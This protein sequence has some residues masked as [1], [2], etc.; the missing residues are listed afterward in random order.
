M[1]VP[2]PTPSRLSRWSNWIT[3]GLFVMALVPRMI[4]LHAF[5]VPDEF[6]WLGRSLDAMC[7]VQNGNLQAT[8]QSGHPGVT[9]LWGFGL[10]LLARFALLGDPSRI[11][12][13]AVA[14][15]YPEAPELLSTA[16]LFTVVV[17]SVGV[18]IG[19]RAL[20]HLVGEEVALLAA[21]LVA[22]DPFYLDQ[23][24]LVHV[25][26]LLAT[27]MSLSVLALLAHSFGSGGR[28]YLLASGILAGLAFLTKLPSLVLIPFA[29]LT[30]GFR[31]AFIARPRFDR[32]RIGEM[33]NQLGLWAIAA[34]VTFVA[35]WPMMW[36]HPIAMLAEILR[37]SGW[38]ASVP[39]HAS[40]FMGR[41]VS[42][43]GSLY[44][45]VV[46]PF[47]LTPLTM[48]AAP[49]SLFSA[50]ANVWAWRKGDEDARD[51][52]LAIA[53]AWAF[54]LAFLIPMSLSAKKGERY[55]LPIFPIVDF[56][57]AVG[58][59]GA[60]S[61]MIRR[62][63]DGL[64]PEILSFLRTGLPLAL[65]LLI[66]VQ[67][68]SL[69][70]HYAA[71]YNPILGG[72]QAA[73][74]M[75]VV[76]TGEGL[77][78]AARYLDQKE[79]AEH[80]IVASFYPESF[81]EYFRGS[82]ISLRYGPEDQ[83]W[84]LSDYVVFYVSQ[85]QRELPTSDMVSFFRNQ[86][87]EHV[88]TINGLEYAWVYP[89]PVLKSGANPEKR[90]Q[91]GLQLGDELALDGY[92]IG[93]SSVTPG[94]HLEFTL[95]WRA[96]KDPQARYVVRLRLAGTDGK[97]Y[98]EEETEPVY[99]FFPTIYWVS[100]KQILDRYSWNLADDF[101]AGTYRLE[102]QLVEAATGQPMLAPD[103]MA[104]EGWIVLQEIQVVPV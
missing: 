77:D 35:L 71:Y 60:S 22:L 2:D 39:H 37:V 61:W 74:R 101:E 36:F 1:S 81:R 89:S 100:G 73:S 79:D 20:R 47:R 27:F 59:I 45:A 29:I 52:A 18:M 12:E 65:A 38:G 41:I 78:L 72:P 17:T 103:A 53:L 28:G 83:G 62:W 57:A 84:L 13:L 33:V 102:V 63:G 66:A 75:L 19:Y 97:I 58:L 80:L 55:I 76:G 50:I 86:T 67:Y 88:V 48:I 34:A 68:L 87:P 25:D 90:V 30:F 7:G 23:A 85:V 104:E 98:L 8:F 49:I 44:Y 95:R 4:G 14:D 99:G 40:Y 5:I 11:C 64:R 3:L 6:H 32:G 26:A 51:R 24:R 42:D 43:P 16:A 56:L 69:A 54:V 92:E 93:A 82:T 96:L 10:S 15:Q 94:S 46:L 9:A 31:G 21:I 91:L 70:P